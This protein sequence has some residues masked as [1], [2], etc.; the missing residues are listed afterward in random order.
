VGD[1][2][3]SF[4]PENSQ[5]VELIRQGDPE[6]VA[7]FRASHLAGI[8]AY[9]ETACRPELV[10]EAVAA[11]FVDFLGRVCEEELLDEDLPAVLLE[12]TRSAASN[13]IL[14]EDG[15]ADCAAVPE[16]LAAR[17]NDE[18]PGGDRALH[19]HVLDCPVC[20]VTRS[21]IDEAERA[22]A[23]GIAVAEAR[24]AAEPV[25]EPAVE[26]APE[27]LPPPE[28]EPVPE[29]AE[30]A[31]VA[32]EPVTQALPAIPPTAAQVPITP[33]PPPIVVRRRSGGLLGAIRKRKPPVS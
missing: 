4:N 28:P 8:R 24:P 31:P 22:F 1:P 7:R 18:L 21:R 10:D 17:A 2:D 3:L 23:Q 19:L 25:A 11:S 30:P 33:P 14:V 27:D 32:P 9:A 12:A 16:L 20:Q 6:A 5:L 26:A 13:R 29:P 15:E